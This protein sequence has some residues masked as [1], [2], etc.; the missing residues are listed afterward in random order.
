M[1]ISRNDIKREI[2]PDPDLSGQ[3][4]FADRKAQYCNGEFNHIG[5][6]AVVNLEIPIGNGSILQTI[7]SP[8]LW[9]I[10]SDNDEDYFNQVFEEETVTLCAM[11]AALG[12]E[13]EA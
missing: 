7:H 11:L 2:L 9:G 6:S 8:G 4:N 10:D 13:V 12:V 1:K 5:V 3:D